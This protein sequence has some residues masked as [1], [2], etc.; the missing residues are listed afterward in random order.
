M[1]FVLLLIE[2]RWKR[3]EEL[4]PHCSRFELT[5]SLCN[6]ANLEPFVFILSAMTLVLYKVAKA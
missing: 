4:F 2:D 1:H 6:P 3:C 5:E